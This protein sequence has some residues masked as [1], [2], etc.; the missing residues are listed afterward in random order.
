MLR[1]RLCA[2]LVGIIASSPVLASEEVEINGMVYTCTNRCSV[3]VTNGNYPVRD[4][5]GGRIS[6]RV[7]TLPR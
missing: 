3:T 5:C 1:Y 6:V 4:C 7:F 2:F